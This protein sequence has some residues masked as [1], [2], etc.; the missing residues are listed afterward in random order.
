MTAASPTTNGKHNS[1]NLAETQAAAITSGPTPA[2]SPMVIANRGRAS[3]S[4]GSS[5]RME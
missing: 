5:V 3:A 4:R 2:A 1:C